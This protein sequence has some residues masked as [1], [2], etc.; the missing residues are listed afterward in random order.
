MN[1]LK[2]ILNSFSTSEKRSFISYLKKKNRRNDT[3]NIALFKLIDSESKSDIQ[4]QL[5]NNNDRQAYHA[6]RKRLYN[7][8]IDFIAEKSFESDSSDEMEV[9]KLVLT[10]RFFFKQQQYKVA[11]K[12]IEKAEKKANDLEL[13]NILNEIYQ[14]Q[15]Q[16]AHINDSDKVNDFI[17]KYKNNKD[18]LTH[19]EQLN[20]A[21]AILRDE[22]NKINHDRKI[23]DFQELINKTINQLNISFEKAIS[24]KS[25]YQIMFITNE[26]A[27]LNRNYYSVESF[28]V[29]SYN[30]IVNKEGFE[31]KHLYYHIHILYF[32]ANVFFRNKKF[33]KAKNYL[34]KMY[35]LMNH[36]KKKLYKRFLLK[37]TLLNSLV[38][39]FIGNSENAIKETEAVLI[40]KKGYDA[41]EIL[42]LQLS[43]TTYYFQ[44][45]NFKKAHSIFKNLLHTNHWYEKK[46]GAEWVMKKSIIEILLH[47]ELT[48]IDYALSRLVSFK[49]QYLNYLKKSDDQNPVI[50]INYI[51]KYI[52]YPE[53]FK[54]KE[55]KQE[56][57]NSFNWKLPKHED[58]FT[59]SFYAWLKGKIEKTNLYKTTLNLVKMN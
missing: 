38:N 48:N 24:F 5:Y 55:F 8:L 57:K 53:E 22:L 7:N 13:Y 1:S 33:D 56:V 16:Y 50:F 18:L 32:M 10:S 6:L 52:H 23:I 11:F 47:I 12:T 15:I 17:L 4:S 42:N 27:A 30:H 34:D 51:E 21:Y 39:N 49:K 41:I 40:K 36:Q 29:K 26:F 58:I 3:K 28:M 43:L 31:S 19:Q 46:I 20:M 45:E 14:T 59:M 54:N 37:Y 44:Q 35:Q 9:L 2:N 25:L